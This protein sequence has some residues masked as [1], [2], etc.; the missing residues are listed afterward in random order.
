MTTLENKKR[1]IPEVVR[2]GWLALFA[3]DGRV[4]SAYLR[5]RNGQWEA[6]P[7]ES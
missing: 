1:W 5:E 7:T 2:E 6:E 3:H 4:P